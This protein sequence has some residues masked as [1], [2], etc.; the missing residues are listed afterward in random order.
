LYGGIRAGFFW[1]DIGRK[2]SVA[3]ET[4]VT[5][6][7]SACCWILR[8]VGEC[9]WCKVTRV[10]LLEDREIAAIFER[11]RFWY[12]SVCLYPFVGGAD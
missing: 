4:C 9:P 3:V 5:N 12:P 8:G 1:V 2:E 7:M 6:M 10:H 11:P